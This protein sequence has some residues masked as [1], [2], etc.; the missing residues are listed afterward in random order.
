MTSIFNFGNNDD[1][2]DENHKINIDE[3]YDKKKEKDLNKL[4]IYKKILGRVH[5]RI[6]TT[7]NQ[8]VNNT[9]CWYVVPEIII[10]VPKYDH[11]SCIA[12]IMDQLRD[13]GFIVRYTHPN[14]LFIS[15]NH[16]VPTYVRNEIKNKTG[17]QVDEYGNVVSKDEDNSNDTNIV[18]NNSNNANNFLLKSKK[19][20]I[21]DKKDDYKSINSYKPSGNLIYN[22]KHMNPFKK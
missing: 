20:N 1:D 15:W 11:G 13:N 12:Y 10:G 4:S 18:S 21:E 7:S 3:L 17:I 6:K 8:Q 2:D 5:V 16:W 14:L 22:E 19:I 9:C